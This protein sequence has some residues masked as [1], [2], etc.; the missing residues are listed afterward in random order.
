MTKADERKIWPPY[1]AF[2]IHSMLF[3][4]QSAVR[5]MTQVNAVLHAVTE[6][7]PEDPIAALP[8]LHLLGELQ[9]LVTQATAVSRYFWPVRAAHDWRGAQPRKAFGVSDESP[10]RARDLR[11]AIEHFDE[12]LDQYLENGI[13]GHIV[14]EYVGPFQEKRDVPVHLFRAYYL[15]TGVFELLGKCYEI[16]PLAGEIGRIYEQLRKMEING[17]RLSRQDA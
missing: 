15:D 13:V 14:P 10:L 1:E 17:G 4:A 9:N 8:V 16:E 12:Q 6:N 2:Y 5:S 11:N 7:S 3:N